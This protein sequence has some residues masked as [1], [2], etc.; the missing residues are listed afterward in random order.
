MKGILLINLGSPKDLDDKSIKEF[1]IEFLSDDLVIDYPKIIQQTLVRG[2]IVPFRYKNTQAAYE[3]IWSAKGSP[4]IEMSKKVSKKLEN[5]ISTPV[6]IGM[7]YQEPSIEQGLR[8][9]VNK[10]C[11]E[12][13]VIP[14][15]P[16]Y[17]ISTTL[18][19]KLKVEEIVRNLDCNLNIEYVDH[20]Y[21][22]ENYIKALSSSIQDYIKPETD[23]LLFSYHG[24]PKRHLKKATPE[25]N[26][27]EE[28]CLKSQCVIKEYCYRHQVMET[29]R[30]CAQEL[31]LSEDQWK[32]SFQSRVGP[33]W[34]QPFTDKELE[35][36]PSLGIKNI[37]VA[38]P[39]FVSDNLE[40]LEE[41]N[42]EARETFIDNGGEEFNY[43]PCLND[44]EPW[45][46]FLSSIS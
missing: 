18:T 40:T 46:D 7:R 17:A 16:H 15:Y 35:K 27:S 1:L 6:E 30:L 19:T 26:H 43:A 33:G 29:S 23:L 22:S 11:N 44:N 32:V 3:E 4:L 25:R 41:I 2:V 28:L 39:S 14:L 12:I 5:V 31:S 34:L 8:S 42:M 10:G 13:K 20:F 45:I 36:Y 21:N 24:I 9:L 37:T 38:C